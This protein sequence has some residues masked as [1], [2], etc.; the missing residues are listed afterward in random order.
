MI[1]I[2]KSVLSFENYRVEK[3]AKTKMPSSATAAP[4]SSPI[5]SKHPGVTNDQCLSH[6]ARFFFPC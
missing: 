6:L 5:S 4:A 1:F 2:A 3:I